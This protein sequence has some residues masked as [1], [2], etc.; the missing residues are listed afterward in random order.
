[1][2]KIGCAF[3]K[4]CYNK[5]GTCSRDTILINEHGKCGFRRISKDLSLTYLDIDSFYKPKGKQILN[6]SVEDSSEDTV[7]CKD[8]EHLMFSDCYGECSK[9]YR[10]IVNPTDTCEHGIKRET[11]NDE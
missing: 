6:E 2:S 1:M 5:D 10:G 9:G 4:C 11:N 8:C 3:Y 7:L